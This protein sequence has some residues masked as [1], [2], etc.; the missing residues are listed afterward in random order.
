[1]DELGRLVPRLGRTGLR[2]Q[3]R[4]A[5]RS[6]AEEESHLRTLRGLV[7]S[8]P[9]RAAAELRSLFYRHLDLPEPQTPATTRIVALPPPPLRNEYQPATLPPMFVTVT[10]EPPASD[11]HWSVT[12]ERR[13]SSLQRADR[14]HLAD[15][16]LTCDHA[17]PDPRWRHAADLLL[18]PRD[19]LAADTPLDEAAQIEAVARHEAATGIESAD[20]GC[21]VLLPTGRQLRSHW[22]E[23]ADWA[24]FE[25]A[26]SVTFAILTAEAHHPDG[27]RRGLRVHVH[28]GPNQPAGLLLIQ[29]R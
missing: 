16:H 9:G 29:A 12:V 19:R 1:M 4:A 26:A 5:A 8:R 3:L 25:I 17:D 10:L 14:S 28:G 13:P 27:G 11:A 23:K 7:T 2:D 6:Q 24:G 15:A 22:L 18:V 21:T 20:H